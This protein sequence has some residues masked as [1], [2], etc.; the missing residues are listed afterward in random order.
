MDIPLSEAIQQLRS[1]LQ[2]AVLDGKGKD[3]VFTPDKIEVEL[4][5]SFKLEAKTGGGFKL[6]TFLDWS[7]EGKVGHERKHSIKLSL[8]VADSDGKPIKVKSIAGPGDLPQ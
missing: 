5:V 7:A 8:S 3:I 2:Q 4:A 1:E 6:L